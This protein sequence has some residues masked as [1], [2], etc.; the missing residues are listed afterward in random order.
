[1]ETALV[2]L[3]F[4]KAVSRVEVSQAASRESHSSCLHF[5]TH[6]TLF[7]HVTDTVC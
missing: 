1:M 7:V 5:K 6:S 4:V 3:M 2:K